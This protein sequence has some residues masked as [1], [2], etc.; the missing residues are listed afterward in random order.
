MFAGVELGLTS[1]TEVVFNGGEGELICP[2][3]LLMGDARHI[4][5]IVI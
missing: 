4:E 2:K 3:I 5:N 1:I